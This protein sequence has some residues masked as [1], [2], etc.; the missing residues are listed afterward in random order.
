MK[1]SVLFLL[2]VF[3]LSSA[4]SGAQGLLK[5]VTGAI[6]DEL[7]N[8]KKTGAD[9]GNE[10]EPACACDQA[11]LI[12]SL[13]GKL[14]LDYKEIKISTMDDGSILLQDRISGNY[15][16]VKDG[17][18]QGPFQAG[19]P[20]IAGFEKSDDEG[21]G[22]D[23]LLNRYK[24]YLNK[25]GDKY[26][27]T[28]GGK[29]YGPYAQISSFVITRSKDK[30]AAF[31]IETVALAEAE[32]KKFEEAVKNAKTDQERMAIVMQ[33]SQQ[34]QEKMIQAG[35]P[36]STLPILVTNVPGAVYDPNLQIG[37]SLNGNMK[38]DD[39]LIVANTRV[40]DLQG[41]EIITLKQEHSGNPKNIFV[42][43]G[44]NA[45]AVYSYGSIMLSNG[46]NLA[47]LFNPHLVKT[48]SKVF[49]AYNYYSPKN[50]AIM[51][52]KIPF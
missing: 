45:Y 42:N 5:K 16:I 3:L 35:G 2:C 43:S 20:R 6:K 37:A 40:T 25:S 44:N 4:P 9:A 50:N 13:A 39:I 52:C 10:P 28:F 31:A 19:D 7:L 41:K 30:F 11:E 51:Q 24:G 15:Y 33:Y 22:I 27:I 17:A 18:N 26:T 14:K 36:P 46:T 12:V 23:A 48:D 34:L 32:E 29:T 1:K 47:E 49:L 21:S 8:V 38:Y